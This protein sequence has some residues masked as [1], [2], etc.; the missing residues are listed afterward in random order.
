M[1]AVGLIGAG[2]VGQTIGTL[3]AASGWCDT[4]MVTSGSGR[5]AA[6]LVTDLEDMGQVTGSHVRAVHTTPAGMRGCDAIVV[7]PRAVFTNTATAD[8]RMAGLEAN[9]PLIA[10]LGRQLAG[11]AGVVVMV[12]NPVDVMTR[13]FAATSGCGRVFGVGSSTDTARYRLTL[14]RL[15]DVPVGSVAGHV[16]GEHGDQAVICA[17][18]TTVNGRPVAVPVEQIRHELTRRPRRINTGIGR[19]RSG[20]AGAAV[21][22]LAHTL[23]RVDGV[24]ELTAPWRGDWYGMPLRF[25]AGTP[26]VCLPPLDA[27]EAVQL[28]AAAA[29]LRTAYDTITKE[30]QHS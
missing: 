24:I 4:V 9:A 5:T 11:Y 1:T 10:A 30:T 27:T 20:P 26:T 19:T 6:S 2:A 22:A 3:L 12:T 21:S 17:S 28:Q 8:V 18:S 23:S 7:C 14:A 16:I 13:L 25:T 15:L 29:K